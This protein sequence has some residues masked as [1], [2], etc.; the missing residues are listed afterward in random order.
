MQPRFRK[1][2]FQQKSE[3]ITYAFSKVV[4]GKRVM[5]S[6]EELKRNALKLIDV[7]HNVPSPD[8]SD[9]HLLVGKRTEHRFLDKDSTTSTWYNGRVISQVLM[10]TFAN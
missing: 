8:N 7:D 6:V 9:P 3:P 2:V 1:N 4:N 10:R 5:L